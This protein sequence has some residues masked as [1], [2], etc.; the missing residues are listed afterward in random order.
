MPYDRGRG[1]SSLTRSFWRR[2]LV[3]VDVFESGDGD[4]WSPFDDG[5]GRRHLARQIGEVSPAST[6]S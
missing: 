4:Q 6:S 2:A 3:L 5:N 1:I